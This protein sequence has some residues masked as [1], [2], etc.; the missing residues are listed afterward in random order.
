MEYLIR[1]SVVQNLRIL[2]FL[3]FSIVL[4]FSGLVQA[5]PK[6]WHVAL[7]Y[8]S[9]PSLLDGYVGSY[10]DDSRTRTAKDEQD[11]KP[12]VIVKIDSFIDGD[13]SI[14]GG[15]IT[16]FSSPNVSLDTA[17]TT[18]DFRS[19]YDEDPEL[20]AKHARSIAA[21]RGLA[22][23]EVTREMVEQHGAEVAAYSKALQMVGQDPNNLKLQK[24][25]LGIDAHGHDI[26]DV[27][28]PV[29]GVNI[30]KALNTPK[31]NLNYYSEDNQPYFSSYAQSVSCIHFIVECDASSFKEIILV[32]VLGASS[33]SSF[34][35]N[36]S[37]DRLVAEL[38]QVVGAGVD[39]LKK[40]VR[41]LLDDTG[42]AGKYFINSA[43]SGSS[44]GQFAIAVMHYVGVGDIVINWRQAKEWFKMSADNGH[45]YAQLALGYMYRNGIGVLINDY[46][47]DKYFSM[48]C[49]ILK[50]NLTK[51]S[52]I[53][54]GSEIVREECDL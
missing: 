46:Y 51:F 28:N 38:D 44:N 1:D 22:P 34:R 48:A 41:S 47:A 20:L 25:V 18:K 29:T 9:S 7:N 6:V 52:K 39:D 14:L 36:G 54:I 11:R 40:G 4:F 13:T 16:H 43:K 27:V 37:V 8:S 31:Y 17:E 33:M 23:S 53:K 19:R 50:V 15:R 21:T 42:E 3:A 2:H 10:L 49:P 24:T 12:I 32:G 30:T 26:A 45:I 5:Q 35:S